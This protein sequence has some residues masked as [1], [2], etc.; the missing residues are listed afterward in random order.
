[1]AAPV[2]FYIPDYD[3]AWDQE[4]YDLAGPHRNAEGPVL[5]HWAF[6]KAR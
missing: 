2:H 4:L 6:K 3:A 5:Q 1:M